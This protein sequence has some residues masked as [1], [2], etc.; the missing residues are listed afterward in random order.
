MDYARKNVARVEYGNAPPEYEFGRKS[1]EEGEYD[2]AANQLTSSLDEK[3]PEL[4]R[5]YVLYYLGLS[6]AQLRQTAEAVKAFEEL[7][8][9]GDRTRFA[10]EANRLLL[11]LY[12]KA[13]QVRKA[14]RMLDRLRPRTPAERRRKDGLVA[15]IAEA[16]GKFASALDLYRRSGDRLGEARCLVKLKR[17]DQAQKRL[18]ALIGRDHSREEYAEIYVLLGDALL[19]QA[20]TQED[21]EA[22]L[23][24]YLRVPAL[25]QGHEETEAK[26]LYEAARILRSLGE[27]QGPARAEALTRLLR[28]KY[29]KSEYAKR[30]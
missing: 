1:F 17:H 2:A 29:P 3:P 28:G 15:R 26:A 20:R 24:A 27:E 14:E 30:G 18:E 19:A 4:V 8:G 5:Q 10:D 9:M 12:V 22:A 7:Q 25:Y 23:L 21:R 6:H 16:R 13:G 11:E